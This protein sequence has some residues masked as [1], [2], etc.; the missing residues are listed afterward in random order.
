MRGCVGGVLTTYR[1]DS[2]V[3]KARRA[4]QPARAPRPLHD[5]GEAG[6]LRVPG[7][8]GTANRY[9]I[10]GLQPGVLYDVRVRALHGS[11]AGH[12]SAVL[13]GQTEIDDTGPPFVT[14]YP[15]GEIRVSEAAAGFGIELFVFHPAPEHFPMTVKYR[16]SES[17]DMLHSAGEHNVTIPATFPYVG[18]DTVRVVDDDVDEPDSTVTVT[19]L[20]GTGYRVGLVASETATVIDDD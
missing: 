10:T 1:T 5:T 6:R 2:I 20:P 3:S 19:V 16:L 8:A 9:T 14:F 12:W 7:I 11:S 18:L 15:S 17:G 13:R 4:M